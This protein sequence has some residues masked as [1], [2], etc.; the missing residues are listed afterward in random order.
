MALGALRLPNTSD[1]EPVKSNTALPY[2]Q[3]KKKKGVISSGPHPRGQCWFLPP[4]PL[5]ANLT[6]VDL[7]TQTDG[8]AIIHVILCRHLQGQAPGLP[9]S[10]KSPEH[11]SHC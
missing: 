6:Q 8:R 10:S 2:P 7:N 5:Q 9:G 1:P 3:G 4:L 11:V